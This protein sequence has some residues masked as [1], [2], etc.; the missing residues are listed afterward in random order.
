MTQRQAQGKL[1]TLFEK[2]E[3]WFKRY[4][5]KSYWVIDFFA[6]LPEGKQAKIK[7]KWHE[8]TPV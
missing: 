8:D 6:M 7:Q 1:H 2:D 5:E 4:L 3:Y